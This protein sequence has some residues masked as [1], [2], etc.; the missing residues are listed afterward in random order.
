MPPIGAA[1]CGMRRTHPRW[2][3]GG[4]CSN[5]GSSTSSAATGFVAGMETK[6]ITGVDDHSRKCV[7][8]TVPRLQVGQC[9]WPDRRVSPHG[10]PDEVLTDNGKQRSCRSSTATAP[11]CAP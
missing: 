8:A 11:C 6:V 3:S 7:T 5:C 1:I 2:E 9:A 10:I 4:W